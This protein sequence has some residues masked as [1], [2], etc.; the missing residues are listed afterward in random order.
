MA[1]TFSDPKSALELVSADADTGADAG[2]NT[3]TNESTDVEAD[4]G[5]D[6]GA[7]EGANVEEVE[8][9][10]DL[11]HSSLRISFWV[12]VHSRFSGVHR[13]ARLL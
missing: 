2:T 4:V 10:G 6:K 9:L 13:R 12:P 3:E 11:T 8:K 1:V 5:T 7:G